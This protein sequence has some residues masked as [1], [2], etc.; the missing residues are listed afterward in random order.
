MLLANTSGLYSD[1]AARLGRTGN[2]AVADQVV[3]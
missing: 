1:P 3:T 2:T